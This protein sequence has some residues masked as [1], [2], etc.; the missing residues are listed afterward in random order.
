VA[1]N[2]FSEATKAHVNRECE[3]VSWRDVPFCNCVIPRHFLAAGALDTAIPWDMDD[4]HFFS[5]LRDR[6]VFLNIPELSITHDRYPDSITGFLKYKWRLRARTGEKLVT[7]P[8]IYCR[9]APLLF[10]G[11]LPWLVL[12]SAAL[13]PVFTLR[14]I[15]ALAV[16]YALLF[17]LQLKEAY[18]HGFRSGAI[19]MGLLLSLHC[20]SV[21]AIQ[22]GI[23][24]ALY[25]KCLAD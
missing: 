16:L 24:K 10:S 1:Q 8:G 12:P 21:L 22:A 20:L 14:L 23:L 4:F 5:G 7:H 25:K 15:A 17:A 3:P 18:K 13:S 11:A 6:A 9:I 2:Y 19:Y